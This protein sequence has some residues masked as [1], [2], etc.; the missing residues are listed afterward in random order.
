[1]LSWENLKFLNIRN[2]NFWHSGG[3]FAYL[4]MSSLQNFKDFLVT[5]PLNTICFL[6][7]P[8]FKPY[9]FNPPPPT[10]PNNPPYRVKN[11][12]SLG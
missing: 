12:L 11:E 4:Q 2:A 6:L 9:F 10:D 3:L 8:P 7:I 1:M 5:P